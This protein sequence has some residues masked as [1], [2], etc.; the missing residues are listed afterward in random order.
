[1]TSPLFPGDPVE[2]ADLLKE[3]AAQGRKAFVAGRDSRAGFGADPGPI[4]LRLRLERMTGFLRFS[5]E[6]LTC[7]LGPGTTLG[8]FEETLSEEGLAFAPGPFHGCRERTLGGLLAES[9]PNPRGFDRAHLRSQCL[10]FEA[11]DGRGRRFAA[12]GR[13]V[14]NVAGYDLMKLFV[15]S[16]GALMAVTRL[17]L[18]L[19]ALPPVI[20]C[21]RSDWLPPLEAAGVWRKLRRRL[22]TPSWLDLVLDGGRA[23]VE[24]GLAGAASHVTELARGSGLRTVAE[25]LEAWRGGG[26]TEIPAG[27]EVRGRVRP[28]EVGSF[29]ESLGGNARGR[30]HYQGAFG[31][32]VGYPDSLPPA[33]RGPPSLEPAAAKIALRLKDR[34]GGI[35]APGRLSFRIPRPLP[36]RGRR[37]R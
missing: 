23:C 13:V 4:D 29:L 3:G 32:E 18:R 11:V 8:E 17:E 12:G 22:P 26:G 25:G 7:S 1:M 20:L 14:K 15:G 19:I 35:L 28:S 5:P 34:L 27:G 33:F 30:I 24:L 6:D 21:L 37:V 10:G 2:L 36:E 31:L 9:P 16:G